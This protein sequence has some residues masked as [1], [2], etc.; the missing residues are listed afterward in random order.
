MKVFTPLVHLASKSILNQPTEYFIHVVTFMNNSKYKADGYDP[1]PLLPTNGKF[2]ITL[3]VKEDAALPEMNLLTPV[4]HSLSIGTI[5]LDTNP[6]LEVEVKDNENA[7]VG[8]KVTHRDDAD[9]AAMPIP[10]NI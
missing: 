3:R 8:N 10:L 7:L 9:E 2:T 6:I 5:N 1:L 4:V